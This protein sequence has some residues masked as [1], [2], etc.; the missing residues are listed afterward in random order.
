MSL[1]VILFCMLLACC[2]NPLTK[3]MLI[4][5]A[6]LHFNGHFPG[7]PG[8]DDVYWSKGWWRWWWQ[9]DN[10]SY[11]SC[12]APVKSSP[13]TN[14]HPYV[15]NI[16]KQIHLVGKCFRFK[17]H[18]NTTN[19]Y[20]LLIFR[21]LSET[22]RRKKLV[23]VFPVLGTTRTWTGRAKKAVLCMTELIAA[24][25]AIY[26]LCTFLADVY[27]LLNLTRLI[28]EAIYICKEGTQSMN[29]DEGSYQ[30]RYAYFLGTSS[31]SS[32]RAKNRKN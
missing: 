8:L 7:E 9:L 4:Y 24:F 27:G 14:Q 31:S 6:S 1:S 19:S 3:F 16:S 25:I 20:F 11:K 23:L 2:H 29:C 17:I 18:Q 28:K 22:I 15:A 13:P 5:C 21:S 30:L 10:W 32:R 26:G 12:K